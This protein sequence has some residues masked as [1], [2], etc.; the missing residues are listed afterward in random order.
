MA[1]YKR[2]KRRILYHYKDEITGFL[3]IENDDKT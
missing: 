3:S 2:A 1:I